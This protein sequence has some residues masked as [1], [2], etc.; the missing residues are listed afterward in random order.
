MTVIETLINKFFGAAINNLVEQRLQEL[1][2]RLEHDMEKAFDEFDVER[3]IDDAFNDYRI[4]RAIEEAVREADIEAI[5]TEQAQEILE[6]RSF[7]RVL[8]DVLDDSTVLKEAAV[9]EIGR[10]LVELKDEEDGVEI[11]VD[12]KRYQI[13]VIAKETV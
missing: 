2:S 13:R 12:G 10:A 11:D 9:Q 3:Q 6:G 5:V 1:D 8:K 7:Q 4:D